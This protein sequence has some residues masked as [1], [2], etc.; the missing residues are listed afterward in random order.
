M[1]A[2]VRADDRAVE[3]G[4][5]DDRD[6]AARAIL[7][8]LV[9]EGSQRIDKPGQQLA[10]GAVLT[11]RERPRFVS[12]GGYK[13]EA[14][15]E[16]FSI[17]VA[18]LCALD[19]GCS[20]GG[21]TDCLLQ[22]GA[23]LV[24]A[25]DVGYGQLAWSLRCDARVSLRERTN[26]RSLAGALDPLPTL[27]VADLSFVALASIV[28]ALVAAAAEEATF[29]LLVKPQFEVA[30]EH[31]DRGVV[32]DESVRRRALEAVQASLAG[33]GLVVE[34]AIESPLRGADGNVEYLVVARRDSPSAE[35]SLD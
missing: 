13:L 24:H 17:D 6:A 18:G 26:V 19:A 32:V 28:P 4:L 9:Y 31:L 11:C 23:A 1:A 34:G 33:L 27:V 2:R 14:A 21:F 8:G 7:A 35:P 20:T 12:R 16:R 25:V 29:V 10:A 3:L 5:A 15:L 22:R 30:R